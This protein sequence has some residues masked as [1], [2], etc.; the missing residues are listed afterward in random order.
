M[1]A[2]CYFFKKVSEFLLKLLITDVKTQKLAK[3][4]WPTLLVNQKNN[5][6]PQ[7]LSPLSLKWPLKQPL[8]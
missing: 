5:C 8:T 1:R 4:V 6:V 2:N 3:D 7:K